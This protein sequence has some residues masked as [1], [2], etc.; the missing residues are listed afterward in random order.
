MTFFKVGKVGNL[1]YL[2]EVGYVE[3]GKRQRFS[4]RCNNSSRTTSVITF[5]SGIPNTNNTRIPCP[6]NWFVI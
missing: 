4:L 5:G 6:R 3:K 2:V 1:T